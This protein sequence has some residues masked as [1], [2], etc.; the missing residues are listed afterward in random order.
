MF[1]QSAGSGERAFLYWQSPALMIELMD[2]LFQQL[3]DLCSTVQCLV[4]QVK[5]LSAKP[6]QHQLHRLLHPVLPQSQT[7]PRMTIRWL[8]VIRRSRR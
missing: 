8:F 4:D 1:A 3:K 5:T 7:L 2:Q 6:L